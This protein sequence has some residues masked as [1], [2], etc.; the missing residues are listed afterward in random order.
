M[1]SLPLTFDVPW[2]GVAA[3]AASL[4]L[5]LIV[6]AGASLLCALTFQQLVASL[7]AVAAFYTLSRVMGAMLAIGASAVAPV[8][9]MAFDWS[10]RILHGI[11]ILL[12]RLDLFTRSQWLVDGAASAQ[13]MGL[14]VAQAATTSALLLLAAQIDLTRKSV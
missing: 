1:F 8:D 10:N 7:A 5:E 4:G 9:S 11:A 6:I 14:V 13:D 12:P 3:W 2:P